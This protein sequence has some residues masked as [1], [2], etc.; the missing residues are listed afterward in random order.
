MRA[1]EVIRRPILLT[2]KATRLR[3]ENNQVIFEVRRAANKIQI[4]GA[5]EALFG[6]GVVA[7]RTQLVRGKD[8]K[9]GR[10]RARL[11]TWKKALVTL[12]AGD[13]IRFFE[14]EG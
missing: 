13:A 14:E 1:E 2:E 4:K 8:R 5:V 3:E 6:V 7:V 10:G 12:K 11:P 9:M